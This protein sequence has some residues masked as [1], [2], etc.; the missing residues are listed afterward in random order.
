MKI[1]HCSSLTRIRLA[2]IAR[3]V[4]LI[5]VIVGLSVSPARQARAAGVAFTDG[6][7]YRVGS[8]PYSVAVGDFNGDGKADLVT[9]N[10]YY[11]GT[12]S[13]LR[14]N[15]NGTFASAVNYGVGGY[16]RSVAVG[17]FNGDGKLDLAV[18]NSSDLSVLLNNGSG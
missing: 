12:V 13:V 10:D 16:P 14:N 7:N 17:D 2:A 1:L 3:F 9:A 4:A 6:V 11:S 18:A 15:G 5:A 8:Y